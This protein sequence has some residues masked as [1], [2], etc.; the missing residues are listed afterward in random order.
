MRFSKTISSGKHRYLVLLRTVSSCLI[1]F[2][3]ST[4]LCLH[5]LSEHNDNLH[6]KKV[7]SIGTETILGW[8]Q[9]YY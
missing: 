2:I 5:C 3:Y 9:N 4:C 6:C 7:Y 8:K 1:V